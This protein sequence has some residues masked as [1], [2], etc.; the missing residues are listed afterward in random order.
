MNNFQLNEI[1]I[2]DNFTKKIFMG[3]LA[4]DKLPKKIKYPS[5]LIINNQKSHQKGEHWLAVYY[6]SKKKATFFDSYGFSPTKYHLNSFIQKTS[7]TIE[8]NK[9]QIQSIFSPYCGLYC[10]LFLLFLAR[11]KSLDYFLKLFKK[12]TLLN[13]K[14]IE[15]MIKK[16]S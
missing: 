10:V 8:Y 15:K 2:K 7:N 5:C 13:D 16:Y 14:L 12:N 3:A 11:G 6:N 4:L 1:L 9:M